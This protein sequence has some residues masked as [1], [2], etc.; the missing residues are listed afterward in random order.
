MIFVVFMYLLFSYNSAERYYQRADRN[1]NNCME[2]TKESNLPQEICR[3]SRDDSAL[4]FS[5]AT[6]ISD[7][8]IVILLVIIWGLFVGMLSLK[9]QIEELKR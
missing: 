1:Y 8:T 9:K 7:V 4:A 5:F 2:Q 6:R 3:Q